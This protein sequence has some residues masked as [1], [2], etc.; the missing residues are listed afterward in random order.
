MQNHE[1]ELAEWLL[2][3]F[4]KPSVSTSRHTEGWSTLSEV[5][6]EA[7]RVV[8]LPNIAP[9]ITRVIPYARQFLC[10]LLCHVCAR[11]DLLRTS[12]QFLQ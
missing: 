12:I 3:K 5:D 11:F 8:Y 9:P 2:Q 7:M 6:I 1:D 10:Q 4:G